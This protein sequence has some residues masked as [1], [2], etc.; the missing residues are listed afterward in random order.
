MIAPVFIDKGLQPTWARSGCNAWRAWQD[1]DER[2]VQCND[3]TLQICAN[4]HSKTLHVGQIRKGIAENLLLLM[5]VQRHDIPTTRSKVFCSELAK[6]HQ[7][8]V[9]SSGMFG[10]HIATTHGKPPQYMVWTSSWEEMFRKLLSDLLS[11][12]L[13]TNGPWKELQDVYEQ[14]LTLELP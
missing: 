7:T 8:C 5:G 14:V 11:L 3:G 10:F 12:D 9:S 2:R 1:N 6:L 4:I 13:N